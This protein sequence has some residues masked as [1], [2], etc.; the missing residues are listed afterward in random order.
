MK[1]CKHM[2][3]IYG[4]FWKLCH[5]CHIASWSVHWSVS[6]CSVGS[7][8]N[9]VNELAKIAWQRT[10]VFLPV[11]RKSY[12]TS[13]K[14]FTRLHPLTT[15]A[16]FLLCLIHQFFSHSFSVFTNFYFALSWKI[17]TRKLSSQNY[18]EL[19]N[20]NDHRVKASWAL[21]PTP[22]KSW[23]LC[24]L[25]TFFRIMKASVLIWT[26]FAPILWP[27]KYVKCVRM[28]CNNTKMEQKRL[29]NAKWL[30][31]KVCVISILRISFVIYLSSVI[32]QHDS[33][34]TQLCQSGS[35]KTQEVRIA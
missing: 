19:F 35:I 27:L 32:N 8:V 11:F 17:Y 12:V 26:H 6:L 4:K 34:Y 31:C 14:E 30:C 23:P 21:F 10:A 5:I 3:A 28:K 25:C 2:N 16:I 24:R 22:C 9:R 29:S 13:A 1:E 7:E 33:I 20:F 15:H 18:Y